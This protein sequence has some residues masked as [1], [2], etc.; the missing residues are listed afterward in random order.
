MDDSLNGA[1][2]EA[3]ERKTE[4]DNPSLNQMLLK[5]RKV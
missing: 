5:F 2:D 4:F 3:S 1:R